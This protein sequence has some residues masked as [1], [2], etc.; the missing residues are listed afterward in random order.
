MRLTRRRLVQ[1]GAA[2]LAVPAMGWLDGLTYPQRALA[3]EREWKHGLSLFGDLKYPAG[4]KH[5]DYVNA[6]A[7]KGGAVR[8]STLGTFD[9][10]NVV[11][12]AVKRSEERRVGKECQ[13]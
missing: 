10:F 13:A 4:F 8:L 7:P 3:Q 2:G 11:V 5:F 1:S 12:G 9:N 6:S